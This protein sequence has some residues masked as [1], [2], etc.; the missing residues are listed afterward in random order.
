MLRY[1]K[2]VQLRF[3]GSSVNKG[4]IT[5]FTCTA[6]EINTIPTIHQNRDIWDRL[7]LVFI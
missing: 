3:W 4:A 7:Y 6:N 2:I 5:L 1:I